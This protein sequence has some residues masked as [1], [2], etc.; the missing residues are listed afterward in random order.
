MRALLAR[1][2]ASGARIEERVWVEEG[3]IE[4]IRQVPAEMTREGDRLVV[5]AGPVDGGVHVVVARGPGS[6][7]DARVLLGEVAKATGGRGG[8]RAERAE[9]RMPNGADVRRIVETAGRG[10]G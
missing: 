6:S 3:G 9:G 5:V 4:V 2:I 1:S 7:A 10:E 8:G